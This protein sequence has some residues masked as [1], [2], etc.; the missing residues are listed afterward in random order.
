M[1]GSTRIHDAR[2]RVERER[3]AVEAKLDAIDR[4]VARVEDVTPGTRASPS[5][6]VTATV[7][8]FS[9]RGRSGGGSCEAVRQ[10]FAETIRPHSLDDVEERE[11]LRETIRAELSEPI[12]TALASTSNTGFSPELKRAVLS[13]TGVRRAE[14]ETVYRALEREATQLDG[15]KEVVDEV[16]E[17]IA[18]ADETP[19]TD[20]GFEELQLR[21]ERLAGYRTRCQT[22]ADER[23][24]FLA[25]ATNEGPEIGISHRRLCPYIYQN[26]PTDHPVLATIA[27]LDDTCADCQRAVRD[28]LVRRV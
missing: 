21:H 17:W 9:H 7:G 28:H 11:S 15:A 16:T 13:E 6:G 4:F 12:A 3:D 2:A 22:T 14:T 19:L 18:T 1:A 20:L 23:Q 25:G 26:F 5:P 24:A 27:R 10:A 8:T